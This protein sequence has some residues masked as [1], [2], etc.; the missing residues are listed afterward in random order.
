MVLVT[1]TVSGDLIREAFEAGRRD[2]GE[3]R[4]QELGGKIPVLPREIR[5]HFIGHLQTNKVRALVRWMERGE[6]PILIHSLDRR[7]L[8]EV[9]EK[10]GE[11]QG[12]ALDVLLQVNTSR[13][14]TK[15]GFSPEEF[16]EALEKISL[17]E[18][19]RIKGLMTLGPLTENEKEIR[20]S[21][22]R[23]RRLKENFEKKYSRSS[24]ELSMGMSSDFEIA[25]EEGATMLRIGTA[26]FGERPRGESHAN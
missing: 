6:R 4:V 18:H 2:F 20:E 26:V 3:N 12:L 21:F 22:Q 10:E 8:A 24:W 11:R 25:V 15:S 16:E 9:L 17:L 7:E 1:K 19:L 5:W 23:L 14:T 13:E